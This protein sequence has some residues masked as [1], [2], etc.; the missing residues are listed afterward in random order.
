MVGGDRRPE[1]SMGGRRGQPGRGRDWRPRGLAAKRSTK[2]CVH[3][4][5]VLWFAHQ[6]SNV[7]FA[8]R[9]CGAPVT[10]PA[11]TS[12][13]TRRFPWRPQTPPQKETPATARAAKT[14]RARDAPRATSSNQ[15]VVTSQQSPASR[16]RPATCQLPG[17]A[18]A[19]GGRSPISKQP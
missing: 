13:P 15:P 2:A 17:K 11:A 9:K 4:Q 8:R 5:C 14:V 7:C 12:Q 10:V 1:G 6:H 18:P 16:H 3:K 19:A